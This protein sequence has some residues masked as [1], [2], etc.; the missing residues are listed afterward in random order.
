MLYTSLDGV[1]QSCPV[2]GGSREQQAGGHIAALPCTPFL[3]SPCRAS[4]RT[5]RR[6]GHSPHLFW[7]PFHAPNSLHSAFPQHGPSC[8]LPA[9]FPLSADPEQWGANVSAD[10]KEADDD[11]HQPD[12]DDRPRRIN[13]DGPIFTWRGFVNVGFLVLVV[14]ALLTLFAG[15]PIITYYRENH[16]GTLGGFNL[17]GTNAS[18][19]VPMIPGNHGLIDEDTPKS[20]YH[21]TSRYD[22]TTSMSLVFSDEFN[23]PGRTF[24]PGDDPF[25]EAVNL[26]YWETN[27]LEW[28]HPNAIE[29][30]DGSL[31]I[32]LSEKQINNLNYQGGMM[33]TWNKFCFTGG[34]VE[35]NVSLP[36]LSNVVGLWPAIWT[37]GNLGRAGYGASLEGLWP[38]SYDACDVGTVANQTV[39]GKPIAATENGDAAYGGALSYLPGQRLSRCT[40]PGESH[41]GPKHS[42]GTFVGRAAPEIDMLEA[43]VG[44]TPP[45]GQVSQSAQWA[46]F[47]EAYEWFNT[48]TNEVI[49]DTSLSYQNTYTGGVLQQATSVVTET[50]QN[51]YEGETGCFSVYGV[52]YKPGFDNA[53]VTWISD[54]KHA[55]TLNV[56]G[57]A[58]DSRVEISARPVSQEP[59]Y[60]IMNLGMSHNF[61]DVDLAAIPFPVHLRV[62]YIRVYQPSDSTNIGCDPEDFPTA[63]YISEY[64]EAYNNPNLTT[65]QDDYGHPFPKNSFLG[66]C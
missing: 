48:S 25:W 43:Q 62:D 37:M 57:L 32:T 50:D 61:G 52:E 65:W 9:Q 60:V 64:P 29:T 51:C 26:H 27:N 45:V 1:C 63:K 22:G 12:P 2:L 58:A 10:T 34:Y 40:C 30:A 38:Y 44:G 4:S 66:Q 28:Y 16:M 20:A 21:T 11:F 19:Q 3:R 36:G 55:W 5:I 41:P 49:Y 18:G 24:W 15:Y 39:N 35:A 6:A 47:N 13:R 59:M 23:M 53:Y 8:S 33:S 31:V 54:N 46:P 56:A 42:D 7:D 17:G 14:G